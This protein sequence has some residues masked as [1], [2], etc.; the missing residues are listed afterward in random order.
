MSAS[1]VDQGVSATGT[2]LGGTYLVFAL[3]QTEYALAVGRV[4]EIIGLLPIT[5]VPNLPPCVR[6]V[7]NLRGKVIPVVDLRVRFGLEAVDHGQRT[8]IIVV[9]ATAAEFGVV[10]DR[11]TEVACIEDSAI[12]DPPQFGADLD[13]QYLLGVAKHG[14]KVRLLLDIDHAVSRQELAALTGAAEPADSPWHSAG[15]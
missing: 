12:E 10:V 9:Q 6:G 2:S 3:A 7:I 4:R 8:C 11:V 15:A 5:R 1:A 14:P 13:T